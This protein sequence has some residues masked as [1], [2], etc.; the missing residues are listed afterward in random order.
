MDQK[1][2]IISD[3]QEWDFVGQGIEYRIVGRGSIDIAEKYV[4]FGSGQAVIVLMQSSSGY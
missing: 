1:E 4:P 2:L 3:L